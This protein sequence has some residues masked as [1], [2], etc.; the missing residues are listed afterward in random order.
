MSSPDVFRSDKNIYAQ[1]ID[2]VNGV[3]PCFASSLEKAIEGNG[4]NKTAAHAVGKLVAESAARPRASNVVFD[5]GGYVYHGRVAS[6]PKAPA[7]AA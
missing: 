3:T 2:D 1:I 7:R 4:G 6:W 5:R